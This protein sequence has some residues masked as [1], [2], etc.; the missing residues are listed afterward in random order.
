MKNSRLISVFKIIVFILIIAILAFSAYMVRDAVNKNYNKNS[1]YANKYPVE[2]LEYSFDAE[3]FKPYSEFEHEDKYSKKKNMI[4]R[5]QINCGDI[6][7]PVFYIKTKNNY[8]DIYIDGEKFLEREKRNV[9]TNFTAI[10]FKSVGKSSKKDI[11]IY[12]YSYNPQEIADGLEMYTANK[13]QVVAEIMM[14]GIGSIMFSVFAIVAGLLLVVSSL[15]QRYRKYGLGI[16]GYL[17]ILVGVIWIFSFNELTILFVDNLYLISFMASISIY[18][19]PVAV[20]LLTQRYEQNKVHKEKYRMGISIYVIFLLGVLFLE[21]VDIINIQEFGPYISVVVLAINI[22]SMFVFANQIKRNQSIKKRVTNVTHD[23]S[24]DEIAIIKEKT[25][26]K[27]VNDLTSLVFQKYIP[28]V[29]MSFLVLNIAGVIVNVLT[30]NQIFYIASVAFSTCVLL[31]L[32]GILFS[33]D[34]RKINNVAVTDQERRILNKTRINI[35]VQEQTKLFGE[36]D[37]EKICEKFANNIKGILFPYGDITKSN[38]I[39]SDEV[40]KQY[41]AD[42]QTFRENSSSIVDVVVTNEDNPNKNQHRIYA[43]TN[44]F[45]KYLY[46]DLQ[47]TMEHD[48]FGRFVLVMKGV[49]EPDPNDMAVIIGAETAPRG[50][51]L[52]KNVGKMEPVLKGLLE[53]YLRT[54]AILIENLKLI[55]EAKAIQHDTVYNLNEISEL[56]SKETGYH[57]KRVSLY[58]AILGKKLGLSD[59]DIEILQLASSMHDIGKISIPDRILNKP[60]K[61]TEEEFDVMKTHTTSGYGILKNTNNNVMKVGAIVARYHHEKYNGKGYY[62]LKGE[63]IPKVA[64]IVAVADV[65]DALSVERVYKEAWPLEKILDLFKKERNEHFDGE[66]VDILFEHLEEFIEIRDRYKEEE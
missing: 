51:I 48:E 33:H 38:K 35:L 56:R 47:N 18:Q 42:Y 66:L 13:L 64:R 59:D 11:E 49:K 25:K 17:S 63:E 40:R 53:S 12:L 32:C 44:E 36:E 2:N 46:T 23:E 4:L 10:D 57:I 29:F 37:I 27:E 28:I 30:G 26:T 5:G 55:N 7:N 14:R 31:I 50:M 6:S 22:L 20:L 3:T 61:L 65:F 9:V 1:E 45:E 54:C 39:V 43:A 15:G 41:I 62:G 52:I 21:L 19:V 34:L 16:I 58:S 60:G 8:Y 24:D